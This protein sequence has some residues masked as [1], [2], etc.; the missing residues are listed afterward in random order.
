M[1]MLGA[2]K[3]LPPEGRQARTCAAVLSFNQLV[4]GLALPAVVVHLTAAH[5][6]QRS[7][8]Q[9]PRGALARVCAWWQRAEHLLE[10]SLPR[11]F[12]SM[13]KPGVNPV[14]LWWA[15][16]AYCWIL[17]CAQAGILW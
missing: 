17:A 8:A 9:S 13:N 16:L 14:V 1:L 5:K 4:L 6:Q 15:L 3:P 7:T 2:A 12:F 10:D 11:T